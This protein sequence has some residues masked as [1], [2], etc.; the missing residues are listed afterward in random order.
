M[1]SSYFITWSAL[2]HSTI[3]ILSLFGNP[4]DTKAENCQQAALRAARHWE[5]AV[6]V[7]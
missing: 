6:G 2:S 1:P 5:N 3:A 7:V 4:L